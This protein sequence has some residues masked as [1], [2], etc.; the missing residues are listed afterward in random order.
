L[1]T[2]KLYK[3]ILKISKKILAPFPIPGWFA[4][5]ILAVPRI[6]SGLILSIDFGSSK[7]GM[8]WTD[9]E[10]ELSLFEVSAWFPQD[11]AKFGIPFSWAPWLFAW[12]AAASEAIGGLL[13]AIGFKT[14]VMAFLI[15]CTMLVAIFFQK[16][17]QGSWSMLP[18]MGFLWVGIYSLVLGSG[19]F[20]LD[21]WIAKRIKN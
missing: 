4:N 6:V 20:G 12:I 21:Y 3:L 10:K 17:G 14:R 13:L 1:K 18:A 5:F 2:L 11:V 7:F 8:P 9:P 19:K 15:I 16:W